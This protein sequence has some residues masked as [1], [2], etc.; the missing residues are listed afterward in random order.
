MVKI[1]T[2]PWHQIYGLRN[3]IVHGYSGVNM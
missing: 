1:A 3:R 2:I